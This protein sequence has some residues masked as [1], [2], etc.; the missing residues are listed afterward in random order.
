MDTLQLI[1][2]KKALFE[3]DIISNQKKLEELVSSSC[4]L[5]IGGAGSIGQASDPS[6]VFKGMKMA[7]QYGNK[8][9]TVRNLEVV[10]INKDK[11]YI[12]LKGAVPGATNGIIYIT[13]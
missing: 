7:G 5:V 3:T 6:R 2:R 12:L 1:G 11:N 13:K 4:F 10:S 8:R 9:M